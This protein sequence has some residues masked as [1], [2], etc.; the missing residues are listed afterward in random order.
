MENCGLGTN[1]T[2]SCND[3]LIQL[4]MTMDQYINGVHSSL[5]HPKF[6]PKRNPCEIRINN[7][8]P[9]C[10]HIWRANH[11]IQLSLS[12]H[13]V[14]E[15]ILSYVT[16][17]QKGMSIMMEHACEDAKHGNMDLKES[18]S[19]IGNVFLNGVETS[20]EEAT[21]LLLQLPMI[22]M[23]RGTT[24]MNTF[25]PH[26]RTFL[27]KK[28]EDLKKKLIHILQKCKQII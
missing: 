27:V 9:N 1:V 16:K 11:D 12:P 19:H 14:N 22:Y 4:N 23:T 21:F 24:F 13:A 2:E 17:D 3:M 5:S 20:Q 7:Y 8:M 28:V 25:P 18:V 6:F 26:K 15:Y 10:L